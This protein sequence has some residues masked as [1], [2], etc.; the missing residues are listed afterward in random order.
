MGWRNLRIGSRLA[1]GFGV[2]LVLLLSITFLGLTQLATLRDGTDLIVREYYPQVVR[3]VDAL[4][5]VNKIA[6]S[7]RN[8]LILEDEDKSKEELLRLEQARKSIEAFTIKQGKMAHEPELEP[9]IKAV[10]E[11]RVKAAQSEAEFMALLKRGNSIDARRLLMKEASQ[12]QAQYLVAM[13]ALL[14]RQSKH[15]EQG[16][17]V[18]A[19]L[20]QR[21]RTVMLFLAAIAIAVGVF[22]A[23]LVTRSVVRPLTQAIR[24]AD[25]VASGD[26]SAKLVATGSNETGQLLG[27]LGKMNESLTRIVSEVRHG[28]QT[29]AA[30]SHEISSRNADLSARTEQ[31]AA[32]LEETASSMEELTETVRQNA[33]NA[34]QAYELADATSTLATK[35]G[36]VVADVVDTMAAI[37]E[38]SRKIVDIIGVIDSI[39]FQTNILALN[40]AVE[41]A[42]AGEQGRG[43]AVVAAEVRSLAQR[44]ASAAKEIKGLI[45][46]SVDK[47][48]VGSV[49]VNEA[50][51]TMNQIVSGVHQVARIMGDITAASQEQRN[52]IEQI[53]R[54]ITAMDEATQQNAAMVEQAAASAQSMQDEAARLAD[55]V[56]VFR[57][58]RAEKS[59]TLLLQA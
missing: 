6:V 15:V 48:K 12:D 7:M 51:D 44:S 31:Q 30:A 4:T 14:E 8:L 18:A 27:A 46:D 20:Y 13:N 39:A 19:T 37:N 25:N 23:W 34:N 10:N 55:A 2:V 45:N 59:R 50:G 5:E 52:G 33:V 58:E 43:F 3:S 28:T 29:I 22:A 35:G 17:A 26:L 24:I 54:A 40:A 36:K 57:L 38:S 16:G 1:A 21:S 56:C 41:A 9:L 53:N 42:R 11:A 32:S 47:V 49:L